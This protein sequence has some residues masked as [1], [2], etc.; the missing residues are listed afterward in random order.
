MEGERKQKY[1]IFKQRTE[2][3]PSR[4]SMR[5]GT[6]LRESSVQEILRGQRHRKENSKRNRKQ[7]RIPS[8]RTCFNVR[9]R[10]G[11]VPLWE[12]GRHD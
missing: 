6:M 3:L 2:G 11:A 4:P 10:E 7:H 9:G 12:L 5:L 1:V 8:C